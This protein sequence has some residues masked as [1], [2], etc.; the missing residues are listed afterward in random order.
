ME[1]NNKEKMF[2]DDIL[3]LQLD[4]DVQLDKHHK[5]RSHKKHH[6][7]KDKET[8]INED[9]EEDNSSESTRQSEDYNTEERDRYKSIK[10][11]DT[12][13]SDLQGYEA[14]RL[15]R[16]SDQVAG[17]AVD[18]AGNKADKYQSEEEKE[19]AFDAKIDEV[20]KSQWYTGEEWLKPK[21]TP[22]KLCYN[23]TDPLDAVNPLDATLPPCKP[24]VP[25]KAAAAFQTK[26]EAI[27]VPA[28]TVLHQ[29][30][31]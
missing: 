21:P 4:S 10:R 25:P 14:D 8:D 6:H 27:K 11:K 1:E 26:K 7:K 23:A 18:R 19:D 16:M 31:V 12:A 28:H 17:K 3:M 24:L 29:S 13:T 22:G 15:G 2:E 9:D 5:K 30:T 20:A